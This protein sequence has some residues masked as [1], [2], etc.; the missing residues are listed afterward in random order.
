MKVIT[1]WWHFD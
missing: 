1:W